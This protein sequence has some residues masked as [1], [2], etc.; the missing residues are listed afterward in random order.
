MSNESAFI[1][2]ESAALV[3]T[4]IE[5]GLQQASSFDDKYLDK[6]STEGPDKDFSEDETRDATARI[7]Y[8]WLTAAANDLPTHS[9][10][11]DFR[12]IRNKDDLNLLR[13]DTDRFVDMLAIVREVTEQ[14][15]NR[16][17]GLF[18][19]HNPKWEGIVRNVIHTLANDPKQ[20]PI[21]AAAVLAELQKRGLIDEEL[22]QSIPT[23]AAEGTEWQARTASRTT[24]RVMG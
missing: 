21:A 15:K 12:D 3:R 14:E 1:R 13:P 9:I 19:N 18:P 6:L 17:P 5:A 20:N 16:T 7:R 11:L 24:P 23:G 10:V 4:F 8:D 2:L 22:S